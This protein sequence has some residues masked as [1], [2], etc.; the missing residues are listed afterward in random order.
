M[1]DREQIIQEEDKELYENY[2]IVV[3]KGQG[4]LRIDKF[5]MT[6]IE[7]VSRNKIQ[8][9]AQN[10]CIK[11]NGQ[12]VKPHYKVKS[13]ATIQIFLTTK[14]REIEIIQQTIPRDVGYEGEE[15]IIS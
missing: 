10:E 3:D 14:P 2:R 5:L 8:K 15:V 13:N 9:A 12:T 7:N 11:V 4:L 1:E 6:R